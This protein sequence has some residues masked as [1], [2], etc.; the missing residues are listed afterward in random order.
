MHDQG[1]RPVDV[2]G[3]DDRARLGRP[4]PA[5]VPLPRVG[6]PTSTLLGPSLAAALIGTTGAAYGATLVFGYGFNVETSGT[7]RLAPLGA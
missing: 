7:V 5:L 1:P 3:G 4:G 6:W 2:D